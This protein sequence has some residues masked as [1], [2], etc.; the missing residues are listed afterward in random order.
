MILPKIKFSKPTTFSLRF[1]IYLLFGL[2]LLVLLAEGGYFLYLKKKPLVTI[3]SDEYG[4]STSKGA[5]TTWVA[6]DKTQKFIAITGQVKR[7]EGRAL[8]VTDVEKSTNDEHSV[9]VSIS[10]D[11]Y[12]SV[13]DGKF[14]PNEPLEGLKFLVSTGHGQGLETIEG[15]LEDKIPVGSIIM[16]GNIE[17]TEDGFV[18]RNLIVARSK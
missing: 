16:A 8:W 14:L 7:V 5:V 12:I 18:A 10:N 4:T 11:A 2:I 1:F 3:L 13:N 9:Q 15:N 6:T 17:E